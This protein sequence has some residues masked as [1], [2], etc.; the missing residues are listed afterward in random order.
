MLSANPHRLLNVDEINFLV[1]TPECLFRWSVVYSFCPCR[2]DLDREKQ[3]KKGAVLDP[4]SRSSTNDAFEDQILFFITQETI[5]TSFQRIICG[6]YL[7][8]AKIA[9][10]TQTMLKQA[11]KVAEMNPAASREPL[12]VSP[13]SAWIFIHQLQ[14]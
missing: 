12:T 4:A 6:S 2:A 7:I 5:S 14:Y 11:L 1:V 8:D 3:L 10:A 9:P 13:E